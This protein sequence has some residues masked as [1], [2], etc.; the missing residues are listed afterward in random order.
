MTDRM[1]EMDETSLGRL[2]RGWSGWMSPVGVMTEHDMFA[3]LDELREH[4]NDFP[5]FDAWIAAFDSLTARAREQHAE[6]LAETMH[7]ENEPKGFF[8]TAENA[9]GE[10]REHLTEW[11]FRSGWMHIRQGIKGLEVEGCPSPLKEKTAFLENVAARLGMP[12]HTVKTRHGAVFSRT[13][14]SSVEMLAGIP[15]FHDG[16]VKF[17]TSGSNPQIAKNVKFCLEWFARLDGFKPEMLEVR[18]PH[19]L[20]IIPQAQAGERIA[21][22]INDA[23]GEP[24]RWQGPFP[25][26]L[27]D[28]VRNIYFG[29]PPDREAL[30]AI[31]RDVQAKDIGSA[32]PAVFVLGE[33]T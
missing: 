25:E 3:P 23:N 21:Q 8:S 5:D 10:M 27:L 9:R 13:E 28:D 22:N 15:H 32:T 14:M 4:L 2:R 7:E 31:L 12:F 29:A 6:F 26:A 24:W 20:H 1:T 18:L 11:M 19:L 30:R 17:L 33:M 16:A